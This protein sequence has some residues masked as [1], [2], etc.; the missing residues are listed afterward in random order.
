MKKINETF[1]CIHC[2]KTIFPAEKTCRNH[3]PHCF[4]SRHV[5]D[6]IP[7][8]RSSSCQGIMVP[9]NYEYKNDTIRI[10]FA[11][12][13]C[14]KNHRNKQASDDTISNLHQIIQQRKEKVI[15]E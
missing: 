9:I 10:L 2:K 15:M 4:V 5:D 11:C 6:K 1:Q 3:C 14:K 7:G 13:T 8:D 12:Q